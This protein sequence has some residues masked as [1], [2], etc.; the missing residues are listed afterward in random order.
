MTA[1]NGGDMTTGEVSRRLEEVVR[2]FTSIAEKMLLR[3]VYEA[4]DALNNA[5]LKALEEEQERT[6]AEAAAN[7]RLLLGGVIAFASS[8]CVQIVIFIVTLATKVG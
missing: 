8:I 2:S 4:R 7:R 3:E 6:R 1:F 5:R